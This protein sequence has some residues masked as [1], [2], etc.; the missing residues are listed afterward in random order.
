MLIHWDDV[1]A[2]V[3][4]RGDLRGRRR[5]LA[6]A[7]GA[8]RLGLSRYEIAPGERAMPVHLHSD[9][10]ELFFVLGGSGFSVEDDAAYAIAA[11]RRRLLPGGRPRAHRRGRR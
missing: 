11:G 2:V 3:I 7:C 10:E 9:E 6:Q 5:R 4:D 1:E 8:P